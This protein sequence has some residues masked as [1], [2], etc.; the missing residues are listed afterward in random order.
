METLQLLSSDKEERIAMLEQLLAIGDEMVKCQNKETEK[1]QPP[2]RS[3]LAKGTT[4][5]SVAG[6]AVRGD[7]GRRKL[8]ERREAKKLMYGKRLEGLE[9][10]WLVKIV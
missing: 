4:S 3:S 6:A 9:D 7:L 5:R 1:K 2:N 8:E 10:N